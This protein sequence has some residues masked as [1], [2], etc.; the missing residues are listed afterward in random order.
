MLS[1]SAGS[2]VSAQLVCNLQPGV[3]CIHPSIDFCTCP[4]ALQAPSHLPQAPLSSSCVE[5]DSEIQLRG[6]FLRDN[7][8]DGAAAFAQQLWL[9]AA[10]RRPN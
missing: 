6:S 3:A 1:V 10:A 7:S 4:L 2:A 9:P 5:P 8:L